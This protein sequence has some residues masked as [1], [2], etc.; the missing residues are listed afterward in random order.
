VYVSFDRP[1][2]AAVKMVNTPFLFKS[3]AASIQH[4]DISENQS[5]ITYQFQFTA[6]PPALQ[7]ILDPV[8][9]KIFAWETRKRLRALRDFFM[10]ANHR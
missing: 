5:Q 10:C 2:L 4:E 8:L 1:T 7:F 3:W 9:E 6:N